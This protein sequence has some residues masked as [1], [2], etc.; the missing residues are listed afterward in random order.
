MTSCTNCEH[1]CPLR[2]IQHEQGFHES[3]WTETFFRTLCFSCWPYALLLLVLQD[4]VPAVTASSIPPLPARLHS[5]CWKVRVDSL[6]QQSQKG[7]SEGN[8]ILGWLTFY[9]FSSPWTGRVDAMKLQMYTVQLK[10][11]TNLGDCLSLSCNRIFYLGFDLI[12]TWY[13]TAVSMTI[14][15]WVV[16]HLFNLRK[17]RIVI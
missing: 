11:N 2:F 10:P 14:S 17:Q 4:S 6:V 8:L 3:Q 12:L 9:S 16:L 15:N 5:S 1:R 13:L 7:T